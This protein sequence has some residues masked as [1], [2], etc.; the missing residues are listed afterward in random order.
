MSDD[1]QVHG[2][3]RD[4][5]AAE[6]LTGILAQQTTSHTESGYPDGDPQWNIRLDT[7]C[8]IVAEGAYR[9]AD[10]MME[11]RQKKQQEAS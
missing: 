7:D 10:A 5:F 2:M 9:V 11:A 1:P 4:Y 8:R 3:L 6:A